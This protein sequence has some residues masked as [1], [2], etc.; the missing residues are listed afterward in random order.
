[1]EK[2]LYTRIQLKRDTSANWTAHN[3][4]LKNGEIILVDTAG[5]ELRM[6]VGDGTKTYAQLPFTD[7][8]L[9]SQIVDTLDDKADKTQGIFYIEGSG[10]TDTTNKVAMWTGSHSDITEYYDG[11]IIAYKV[12]IAGST[13]TT[14]NINGLG[15][16][17]V[18]RNIT[19]AI[20][21]AYGVNAIV[22][23]T[24]TTDSSGTAYWKVADYDTNNY[25]Y[26]RQYYTTTNNNF[27][28]LFKYDAGLTS[29]TS[30]VT[31]Y[32]RTAN[33]MYVNPST[34]VITAT[35]FAGSLTGNADT[36]TKATQDGSGNVITST[37]ATKTALTSVQD[38]V[39]DVYA[40]FLDYQ[41]AA[42]ARLAA[43]ESSVSEV[44]NGAY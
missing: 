4:V 42:N 17:T 27:P 21:T 30:Y 1:M 3:P 19:T 7:E 5:G 33:N 34:G 31:K 32:T 20:S 22:F 40:Q 18:V 36:A 25:A 13:T 41:V 39:D 2:Q 37:Y 23:L 35:K 44:E 9:R 14:L 24:Y 28:L 29:T 15:A 12:G 6:K 38:D 8:A 10:T 16:V 11:L 43:L 26:V